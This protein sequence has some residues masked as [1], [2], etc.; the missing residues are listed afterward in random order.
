MSAN[1][2]KRLD[3]LVRMQPLFLLYYNKRK[4]EALKEH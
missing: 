1:L 2:E 4:Q 3:I